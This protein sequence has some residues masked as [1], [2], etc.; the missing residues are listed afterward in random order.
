MTYIARFQI[1]ADGL[2]GIAK[3]VTRP[4]VASLTATRTWCGVLT[5]TGDASWLLAGVQL[6]GLHLTRLD[7]TLSEDETDRKQLMDR[8]LF[9]I[10]MTAP[11]VHRQSSGTGGYLGTAVG[12]GKGGRAS[13]RHVSSGT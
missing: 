9:P 5:D 4:G 7:M 3:V 12:H 11:P 2:G 8:M 10:C 6:E 13:S 1:G